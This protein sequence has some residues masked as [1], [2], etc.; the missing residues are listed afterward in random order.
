VIPLPRSGS[1][2]LFFLFDAASYAQ[3]ASA[4]PGTPNGSTAIS[5]AAKEQK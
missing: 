1:G 4:S 3:K 2:F 5:R